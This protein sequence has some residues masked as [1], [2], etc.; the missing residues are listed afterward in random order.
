MGLSA[1]GCGYLMNKWNLDGGLACTECGASHRSSVC[2]PLGPLSLCPALFSH[3]T[4]LKLDQKPAMNS[5]DAPVTSSL[6]SHGY[7]EMSG[8]RNK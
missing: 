7:A 4:T 8:Q 5:S 1:V 2:S 6:W 3:I